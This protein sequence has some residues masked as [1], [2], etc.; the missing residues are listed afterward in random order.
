MTDTRL[1]QAAQSNQWSTTMRKTRLAAAAALLLASTALAPAGPATD[2][3]TRGWWRITWEDS[4]LGDGRFC[5][6]STFYA[7]TG[8]R[9]N[10]AAWYT[11]DESGKQRRQWAIEIQQPNWKWI[12]PDASY[13]MTLDTLVGPRAVTFI[14][15]VSGSINSL[16]ATV[17]KDVINALAADHKG[18]SF[19]IR[20]GNVSLGRYLLDDSAAAI[21]DIV[22]CT[23]QAEQKQP[24]AKAVAPVPAPAPAAPEP[25]YTTGN[26][27]LGN[28]S[29]SQNEMLMV[30]C[31]AY[32]RGLAD[33]L[34]LG[35]LACMPQEVIAAQLV[36]VGLRSLR[37][38][39]ESRHEAIGLLL[40][41]AF[42]EAWPCQANG[43]GGA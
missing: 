39:P 28:C 11:G 10:L 1:L 27:Y 23:Q 4:N 43:R 20:H 7:H 21:R 5:Q 3:S 6:A 22:G 19:Q 42:I 31:L 38:R 36:E 35:G 24:S 16:I 14:G 34:V 12:K 25:H 17:D 32:A 33:G 29:N 9:L 30:H 41:A 26:K 13:T 8:V 18:K 37:E 2:Y 15:V 40:S